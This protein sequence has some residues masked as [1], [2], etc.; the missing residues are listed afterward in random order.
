MLVVH[1]LCWPTAWSGSGRARVPSL[2]DGE[3]LPLCIVQL[4]ALYALST[5]HDMSIG[6]AR[7]SPAATRA[8]LS[9]DA[10]VAAVRWCGCEARKFEWG[11][12]NRFGRTRERC[13]PT[14]PPTHA[15]ETDKAHERRERRARADWRRCGRARRGTWYYVSAPTQHG[16]SS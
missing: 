12:V 9:A 16:P 1:D 15:L 13:A 2:G 7:G 6:D 4:A 14:K 11:D 5:M 8:G 10:C 3:G